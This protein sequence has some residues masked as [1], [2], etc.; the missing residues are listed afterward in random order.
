MYERNLL[1]L[2]CLERKDLNKAKK[3]MQTSIENT[4]NGQT[5]IFFDEIKK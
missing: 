3:I 1:L 4:L 2:Q 5:Q